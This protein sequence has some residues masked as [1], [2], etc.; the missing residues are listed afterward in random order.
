MD[1]L[2][3]HGDVEGA[4]VHLLT[5][6]TEVTALSPVRI[7]TSLVGYTRGDLWVVV[8]RLGGKILGQSRKADTPRVDI[9]VYGSTRSQALQLISTIQGVLLR[10]SQ[11]YVGNGLRMTAATVESGI[12]RLD[13][14][15][16][17]VPRYLL[18]VRLT[19]T[20][21]S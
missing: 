17:E 12:T 14:K 19:C 11:N 9:D 18:S 16:Q 3:V 10:D 15:L 7:S 4:V 5:S 6:A 1:Q 2:I 8:E 13:D 20:P 21:H